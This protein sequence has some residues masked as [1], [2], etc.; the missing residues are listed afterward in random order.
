MSDSHIMESNKR[1]TLDCD[2]EHG[3][4]RHNVE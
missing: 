4:S 3:W 2:T 1:T